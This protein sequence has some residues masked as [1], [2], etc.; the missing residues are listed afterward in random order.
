[1]GQIILLP[2]RRKG[3]EPANSGTRG[4]RANH[5]T[6]DAVEERLTHVWTQTKLPQVKNFVILYLFNHKLILIF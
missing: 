2:L 4:Q 1:M 5:Q 3:I 6:T